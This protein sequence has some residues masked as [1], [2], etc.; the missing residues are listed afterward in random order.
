MPRTKKL[1]REDLL[2]KAVAVIRKNGYRETSLDDLAKEFHFTKPALYYYVDSKEALLFEIYE[3]TIDQWLSMI[4]EIASDG[5]RNAVD[6]IHEVVRQF[7]HLCIE[8]DEMAIFFSEKAYLSDEHFQAISF[9]E[10]QV[11]D[12]IANM[13]AEGV[14]E[15][16]MKPVPAKVVAYGLVGM[17]A[18]GYRWVSVDGPLDID[19]IADTYFQVLTKGLLR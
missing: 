6:K 1:D 12:I 7:S 3:N 10:R 13:I 9:K 16:L 17:T 19:A 4:R 8:H 14:A 11:V 2:S 15:G 5:K 18:W